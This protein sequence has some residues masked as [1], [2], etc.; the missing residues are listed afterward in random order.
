MDSHH[1]ATVSV[2]RDRGATWST[3]QF[4]APPATQQ[5]HNPGAY[6]VIQ[7]STF[8]GQIVNAVLRHG[9]YAY[10]FRTTDGGST[11]QPTN[12]GRPLPTP[13]L[14]NPAVTLP[15]GTHV[16]QSAGT[17]PRVAWFGQ[18]PNAN[19]Y[20][21][22]DIEP[23]WPPMGAQISADGHLISRGDT[24]QIWWSTNGTDW[25]KITPH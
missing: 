23:A 21:Q 22:T 5:Q 14:F 8:D 17:E 20:T 13:D 24:H 12:D 19:N 7:I 6:D 4:G 10:G 18:P 2:S 25:Q 9:Q 15:N 1:N 11:W 3:H 16:L